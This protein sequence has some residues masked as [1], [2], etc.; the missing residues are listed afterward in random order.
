MES[1][2]GVGIGTFITTELQEKQN[3]RQTKNACKRKPIRECYWEIPL[4]LNI[5]CISPK[6]AEV[7]EQMNAEKKSSSGLCRLFHNKAASPFPA[8]S[9]AI[10]ET[11]LSIKGWAAE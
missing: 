5:C 6:K 7:A 4:I 9:W 11:V 2:L 3:A 10:E 8:S 1:L